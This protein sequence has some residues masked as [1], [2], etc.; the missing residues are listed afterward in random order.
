MWLT[1][2]LAITIFCL[3]VYASL[4]LLYKV[5]FHKLK[6]FVIPASFVPAT[7]FTII[8]PA[9]NEENYIGHCLDSIFKQNYPTHLFEVIV[10][11]DHSTDDTSAVVASYQEKHINLSLIQLKDIVQGKLLNAYKKKAISTA[12]ERAK[13]DWIV[14]TDADCTISNNWLANYAAYIQEKQPAFVAAP[15]IF[16]NNHSFVSV[17]QCLDF[18]SLQGITAAAV[19]AGFHSMCNGANLA[20]SKKAFYA[21]NGFV[22]IDNIASGDDML[23]MHKIKK[24]FPKQIGL[25]FSRDAIVQTHPMATWADFFNQR[26]RWA[27]KADKFQDKRIIAVLSIVYLMNIILLV[28]PIIAMFKPILFL[29][30]LGFVAFKM[31]CEF[32]F[33]LPAAT[34]FKQQKLLWWFP[35]MQLPHLFYTVSAGFLGKFGTYKWKGR[36]VK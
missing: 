20:Y 21:V 10:V 30:W 26:I 25:L 18:I 24:A 27:S 3:W 11:D 8:I 17:F 2:I 4:I 15:V 16:T 31:L 29:Y 6:P 32:S 19:T 7:N 33:M 22:G 1:I 5:W 28:L 23:L 13:G 35:I 12:I 34:F 14:T 36:E 9:R